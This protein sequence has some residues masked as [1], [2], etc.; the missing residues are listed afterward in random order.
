MVKIEKRGGSEM[1]VLLLMH[2]QLNEKAHRQTM[3][4]DQNGHM[5]TAVSY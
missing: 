1:S 2:A 5:M 3:S 4:V